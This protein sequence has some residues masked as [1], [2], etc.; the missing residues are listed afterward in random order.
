[1]E[2]TVSS[3]TPAGRHDDDPVVSSGADL[4]FQWNE[5]P[6]VVPSSYPT[7]TNLMKRSECRQRLGLANDQDYGRFRQRCWRYAEVHMGAPPRFQ[8]WTS[9]Q[10]DQF[11]RGVVKYLI[12]E[13]VKAVLG[14]ESTEQN[15]KHW[16]AVMFL[17]R[18]AIYDRGSNESRVASGLRGSLH[19]EKTMDQVL[20]T[21]QNSQPWLVC[22]P[23]FH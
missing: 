14:R 16:T 13:I 5:E 9:E 20:T 6:I 10:R 15:G 19:Q 7:T 23:V 3:D 2:L 8:D 11:T 21:V 1:M 12:P 4:S 18:S 17:A 22:L